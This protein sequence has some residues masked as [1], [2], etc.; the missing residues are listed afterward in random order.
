MKK[1]KHF[2][3]SLFAA[4]STVLTLL[5]PGSVLAQESTPDAVPEDAFVELNRP[6]HARE[7]YRVYNPN[8]GEHF[9][10]ANIF[11]RN[12]LINL[13]WRSEGI[14]WIA[15]SQGADVYRLYNPWTGDHH[16]TTNTV[17][18]DSLT[19]AGWRYEGVGWKSG[20]NIPAYRVYNPNSRYAGSHH[21]TTSKGEADSLIHQGW[22]NEQ[23]GWMVLDYGE[24]FPWNDGNSGSSSTTTNPG[25]NSS[26]TQLP[27][28]PTTPTN[29]ATPT[30]PTR[31]SGS[32]SS[33]S[34]KF[35]T[36]GLHEVPENQAT[37][38][39]NTSKSS[40]VFHRKGCGH[41]DQMK[42]ENKFYTDSDAM[43]IMG[44]GFR[45]CKNCLKSLQ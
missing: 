37:Y 36:E 5:A 24:P 32:S 28:Q 22:R 35:S 25:Q 7:M 17:E 38:I 10:T 12:D 4:A 26:Q 11:E 13:G 14:G 9:Y 29:P 40:G 33:N 39:A 43:E 3:L 2:L 44:N 23:V 27:S 6:D 42:E 15:P 18:R 16:Y 21:Y 1:H 20:G 8:N 45:P 31:P 30:T 41:V 34:T 19:K